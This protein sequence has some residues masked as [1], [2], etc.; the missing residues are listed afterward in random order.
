[1]SVF[2]RHFKG[3]HYQVLGTALDT[4]TDLPV[5]VYRTLYPSDHALFTRPH[6][7]FHGDVVL[8]DGQIVKRFVAVEKTD[9]PEDAIDRII[10]VLSLPVA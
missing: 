8:A 10:T 2:Y 4:A 5:V 9:L 7:E 6:G 3:K 1:M